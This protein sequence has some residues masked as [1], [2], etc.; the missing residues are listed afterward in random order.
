M[1][2]I[3]GFSTASGSPQGSPSATRFS[4]ASSTG[5]AYG[6]DPDVFFLREENCKLTAQQKQTLARV[7]A[8]FSGILLT[9]DMP[10]R[11]TDEMRRQYNALRE[12]TDHAENCT[13]DA[14]DGL[15]VHYTLH[16]QQQAFK[17]F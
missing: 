4:A 1:C 7:N 6:S 8:L 2:G 15:T 10:S 16:G 13:V 17:V 5:R 9:S 11:Y 12:L 14:D 3:C